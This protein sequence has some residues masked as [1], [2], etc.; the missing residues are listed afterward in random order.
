MKIQVNA[1]TKEIDVEFPIFTKYDSLGEGGDEYVSV[2]RIS[3]DQVVTIIKS[4]NRARTEWSIEVR[5]TRN[6][7][8]VFDKGT[9]SAAEFDEHA[10]QFQ[11]FVRRSLDDAI[12]S[13]RPAALKPAGSPTPPRP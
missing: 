4:G 10:A 8:D 9:C 12:E 13:L 7:G 6:S 11:L 1:T 3:A 2:S 5:E